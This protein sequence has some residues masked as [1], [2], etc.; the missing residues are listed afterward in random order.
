MMIVI[1]LLLFL[2]FLVLVMGRERFVSVASWT[3]IGALILIVYLYERGSE[4]RTEV[5]VRPTQQSAPA[6]TTPPPNIVAYVNFDS[7]GIFR[8][9]EQFY[10]YTQERGGGISP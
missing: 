5:T 4:T 10:T 3:L 2:I 1:A 8:I 6:V 9:S 7:D